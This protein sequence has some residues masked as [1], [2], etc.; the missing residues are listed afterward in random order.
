[1]K[2]FI[3]FFC[4]SL[5]FLLEKNAQAQVLITG[6]VVDADGGQP[7]SAA[8]IRAKNTFFATISNVEGAFLLEV[9]ELPVKLIITHIGYADQEVL[10][11]EVVETLSIR[12]LPVSYELDEIVAT[13]DYSGAEIMRKVIDKKRQWRSLLTYFKALA[14]TRQTVENETRIVGLREI[15]SEIH[16]DHVKGIREV[17]LSKHHT[18]NV[19]EEHQA[20]SVLKSV[21]NFYDDEIPVQGARVIGPTHPKALH[22]YHFQLVKKQYNGKQI[23][24]EVSV[25]PKTKLQP[26]FTGRLFILDEAFV[27]IRAELKPSRSVASTFGIDSQVDFIQQ[28]QNFGSVWLPIDFHQQF[29]MRMGIT[30]LIRIPKFKITQITHLKDFEVNE[31]LPDT[32]YETDQ[33]VSVDSISVREDSLFTKFPDRVPL[34]EREEKAHREIDST[35]TFRK[36]FPTTGPLSRWVK[37]RLGSSQGATKSQTSVGWR[38]SITHGFQTGY[39]RVNMAKVGLSVRPELVNRST[40][41]RFG[42]DL[43]TE[44]TQG[45][46]RWPYRMGLRYRWG[47]ENWGWIQI[48]HR[49]ETDERYRS[50]HYERSSGTVADFLRSN[51]F[52]RYFATNNGFTLLG[53]DD[54]YDYYWRESTDFEIMQTLFKRKGILNVGFHDAKHS[55]LDKQTDFNILGRDITQRLNPSIDEGRLRYIDFRFLFVKSLYKRVT[56]RIEWSSADLLKSDFSYAKYELGFDWRVETFLKRRVHPN[57]LDVRVTAGT[58]TGD[59][60]VQRFGVLDVWRP[61]TSFGTFK[62]LSGYP[63]EGEK[64][65]GVY[66]QHNFRSAPFEIFNMSYMRKNSF[67]IILHGGSGRTWISKKKLDTLQYD[68]HVLHKFYHEAGIS[69][70]FYRLI[71]LDATKRLDKREF[72]V[73]VSMSR[74]N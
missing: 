53:L 7:L 11:N 62:H 4:V 58:F 40:G 17:V 20:F 68:P 31:Q 61:A 49:T 67:D 54:Y 41:S 21:P 70:S 38:P 8:N 51:I 43:R 9:S 22:F 27:I 60:P 52:L 35:L 28:F 15:V 50:Y 37:I 5:F 66:W 3:L 71:R 72:S 18:Q 6:Q 73:R 36:A 63:Y 56:A 29:E 46:S 45:L 74:L 55:S 24:Y 10:V 34:S 65:V 59:L 23:I 32:L 42:L 30:G 57:V 13:P 19:P 1:M 33:I 39:N 26:T 2:V 69:L 16:W 14:Y 44:Y 25:S 47:K 48:G 12:M 64:Y